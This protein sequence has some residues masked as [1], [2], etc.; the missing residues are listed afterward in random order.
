VHLVQ[1]L[2]AGV[3]RAAEPVP[4]F[5]MP[6]MCVDVVRMHGPFDEQR[7]AP[8]A[9]LASSPSERGHKVEKQ[10]GVGA[11]LPQRFRHLCYQSAVIAKRPY[12]LD[13]ITLED[14]LT[15]T[16]SGPFRISST[17]WTA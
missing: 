8:Q 16:P 12:C 11:G 3:G 14:T 6:E 5:P 9:D 17:C 15:L 4:Y 7:L 10:A 2:S 13:K 1:Q